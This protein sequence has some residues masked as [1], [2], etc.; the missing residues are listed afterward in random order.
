M[1]DVITS[2]PDAILHG[3]SGSD[4]LYSTGGGETYFGGAGNDSFV[5]SL[6]SLQ[7]A[8]TDGKTYND[9]IKADAA[10]LDFGGAGGWSA[11]NNDFLALT[12]FSSGS[13]F[14]FAK[15]GVH[16]G[17]TDLTAQFYT[18]HDAATNHDYTI[19][20]HSTDSKQLAK[21]TGDV[22]FY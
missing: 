8:A 4:M 6:A 21:A 5:I 13:T 3:T 18:I 1:A 19:Y 15:Y 10:I 14:T 22:N 2:S 16:N 7:A 11:T 17:S 12:G 20:I 9:T